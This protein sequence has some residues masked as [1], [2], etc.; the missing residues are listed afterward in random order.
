MANY[1]IHW[2]DDQDPR[3]DV[4]RPPISPELATNFRH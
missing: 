3:G 2:N 1:I 4:R